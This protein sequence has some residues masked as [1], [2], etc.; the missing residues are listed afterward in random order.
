M[1]SNQNEKMIPFL[2]GHSMQQ[3]PLL[4]NVLNHQELFFQELIRIL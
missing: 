2:S 3:I 1:I 4:I